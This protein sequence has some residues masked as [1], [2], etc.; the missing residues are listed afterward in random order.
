[1]LV[2]QSKLLRRLGRLEE[3]LVWFR[4][5]E[6]TE[7]GKVALEQVIEK[8]TAQLN[9]RGW[10]QDPRESLA[11]FW[12]RGLGISCHELKA[13]LR[14]QAAGRDQEHVHRRYSA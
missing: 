5:V 10:V 1:M 13:H 8:I 7:A 12:A 9:A 4:Q 6:Q 14:T 3:E 11:E 2:V